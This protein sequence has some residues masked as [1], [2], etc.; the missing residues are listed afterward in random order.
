M[1]RLKLR[2]QGKKKQPTY[3]LVAADSHSPRDG[4]FIEILGH[5]NPRTDP[6]TLVIKEERVLDWLGKGAQPTEAVRQILNTAGVMRRAEE[7]QARA[8]SKGAA[9][10]AAQAP[11]ASQQKGRGTKEA[12]T[13]REAKTAKEPGDPK[14]P[15]EAGETKSREARDTTREPKET[16]EKAKAAAVASE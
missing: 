11:V 16:K 4:R 14:E 6:P 3:R 12:K 9:E 2:R 8:S 15:R 7:A 5:Y 10:S 13:A 1:V